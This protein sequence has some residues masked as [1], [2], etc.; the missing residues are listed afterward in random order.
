[1]DKNKLILILLGIGAFLL[2]LVSFLAYNSPLDLFNC[3]VGLM[4]IV[5]GFYQEDKKINY[6]VALACVNIFQWLILIYIAYNNQIYVNRIYFYY[7][8]GALLFTTTL[9]IQIRKSDMK[10]FGNNQKANNSTLLINKA[11]LALIFTGVIIIIGGLAGFIMYKSSIYLFGSTLGMMTFIYGFYRKDKKVNVSVNYS[12]AMVCTLIFQWLIIACT[13][14]QASTE[15]IAT[16]F[17]FSM[18]ITILFYIQIRES[19]LKYIGRMR[20][21]E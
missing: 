3:T 9:I 4:I 11:K 14:G 12:V 5:L 8:I 2:C 10:Y 20:K 1:M 6:L 19:D 16:A 7:L 13:I 17:S 15:D 21:K 18:T